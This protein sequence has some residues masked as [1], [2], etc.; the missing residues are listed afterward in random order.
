MWPCNASARR[1]VETFIAL[2]P[3]VYVASAAAILTTTACGLPPRRDQVIG[4][5]VHTASSSVIADDSYEDGGRTLTAKE[6]AG[7]DTWYFWTAGNEKFWRRMAI[8]TR[9][10]VDLL[11]YVDSRTHDRRFEALGV[12]NYPKCRAATAPDRYGL[13]LDD[14]AEAEQISRLPGRPIGVVGLR[15]FDN[16]AFDASRWNLDAYLSDRQSVEPPYLVGM[17]CGFC[18]VGFN[19]INPPGDPNRPTWASLSPTIANQYLQEGKLFSLNM[20][21]SDFRWHVASR[22]PPGTSDTSRLATDHI[23][24]PSAINSIFNLAHRP[25]FAERMR[26]G[27]TRRVP[28]VLKDGAD[29]IGIAGAALRVYVNIGMCGDYWMTLHDAIDGVRRAQEPFEPEHARMTCEDWRQTEARMPDA[30]AFL[31][32]PTPLHLSDAPGGRKYLRASTEVLR[33]GKLAFADNCAACH[34]SKQPPV[35]VADR[36]QWYRESVLA[37][38]FLADNFLS[39]DERYP[40]TLIG[41]NIGRA[42]ASNATR[43]HVWDRFSSDTYKELPPAGTVKGL[44]NPRD[45]THPIDFVLPGDG[46]GYYRPPSLAS[47]WATAPYLHNN[48]VG[49]FINDP[50]V[51]SRMAAFEDGIEKLLWPEKRLGPQSIP[52]TTTDSTILIPG[53]TRMLRI[54]AGTPVDYVA[55]VDPTE[56]A[57]L[58]TAVP[59]VNL[60]LRLTPD[61][62]LLSDL[63]RRNLAPDFVLDRGHRFGAGLPDAD[64]RALIEFLKTF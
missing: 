28:H 61:D 55:R 32:T 56:L 18:H 2:L 54:P 20:T 17:S 22:Q 49:V 19:P 26:D 35:G 24:N 50:S 5:A 3:V 21:P 39:T 23:D 62:V 38:D 59:V 63:M 31:K 52:V 16:P 42:V 51:T 13:W 58:T 47:V 10:N 7:R 11:M 53:T 9:G 15:A 12:I 8:I 29:S 40:V 64:K 1:R 45:P 44:Y 33:Q 37:D 34:S 27:S 48:S 36:R 14:C 6:R 25:T 46:R 4:Q 30:E 43:G 57:R 60:A 41:T